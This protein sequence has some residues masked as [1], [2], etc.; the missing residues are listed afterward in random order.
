[1]GFNRRY[2]SKELILRE[3][4]KEYPLKKYFASDACI[5]TDSVSHQAYELHNEGVS[6]KEIKEFILKNSTPLIEQN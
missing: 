5:F 6:D 1:M 4:D 3:I 2:F